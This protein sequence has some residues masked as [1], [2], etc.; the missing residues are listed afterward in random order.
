MD[1]KW[2][3]RFVLTESTIKRDKIWE[4]PGDKASKLNGDVSVVYINTDI[5]LWYVF[6][7]SFNIAI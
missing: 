4:G 1:R 5:Y 7:T 3:T 6:C 2:W